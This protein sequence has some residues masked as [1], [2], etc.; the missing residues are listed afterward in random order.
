MF[1]RKKRCKTDTTTATDMVESQFQNPE[2]PA[3]PADNLKPEATNSDD[4]CARSVN[5]LGSKSHMGHGWPWDHGTPMVNPRGDLMK[6]G[7]FFGHIFL[8]NPEE[9]NLY[10]AKTHIKSYKCGGGPGFLVGNPSTSNFWWD[11]SCK[12]R[13]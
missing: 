6:N 12:R 9:P 8:R 10:L 13:V 11:F 3:E 2:E 4:W 7:H 5:F 1:H